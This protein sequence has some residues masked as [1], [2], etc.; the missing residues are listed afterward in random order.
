MGK[1]IARIRAIVRAARDPST[2]RFYMPP[3]TKD[4]EGRAT[5]LR[6]DELSLELLAVTVTRAHDHRG[7]RI[8]LR[9][10][11]VLQPWVMA[12]FPEPMQMNAC[13]FNPVVGYRGDES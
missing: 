8:A 11:Q 3:M 13:D 2:V 6:L 5:V 9:P 7:R 10:D 1:I 12:Q 4:N